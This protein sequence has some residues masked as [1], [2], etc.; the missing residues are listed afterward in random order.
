LKRLILLLNWE[1]ATFWFVLTCPNGPLQSYF[2][3]GG[4]L[5]G[6]FHPFIIWT[7]LNTLSFGR[8]FVWVEKVDSIVVLG[9]GQ[10]LVCI[11]MQPQ[12]AATKLFSVLWDLM[13][14]LSPFWH[15]N[16]SRYIII[17]EDVCMSWRGWFYGCIG[18]RPILGSYGHAALMG[19]YK[20]IFRTVGPNAEPFT[21]SA[22][23]WISI[24]LYSGG[25]LYELKRL[26]LLLYLEEAIFLVHIDMQRQS[27]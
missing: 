25:C 14:S 20:A 2:P 17:W 23:E 4:T 22:H 12:W 15:M 13:R 1:E 10:F 16:E 9:R 18:K 6:A 26:I 3:Y 24:Y 7:N 21:L 19:R 11:D 27:R 8:M 5:C